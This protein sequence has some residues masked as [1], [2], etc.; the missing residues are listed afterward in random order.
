MALPGGGTA[1]MSGVNQM[2]KPPTLGNTALAAGVGGL[3]GAGTTR[4]QGMSALLGAG[5][6][7]ALSYLIRKYGKG[8]QKPGDTSGG[9]GGGGP[10]AI[11]QTTERDAAGTSAQAWNKDWRSQAS[12]SVTLPSSGPT[13]GPQSVPGLDNVGALPSPPP[14]A[15]SPTGPPQAGRLMMGTGNSDSGN[16]V[17][18]DGGKTWKDSRT[19]KAYTDPVLNQTDQVDPSSSLT[20]ATPATT[21]PAQGSADI[22]QPGRARARLGPD[23]MARQQQRLDRGL[24]SPGTG[25][26][27]SAGLEREEWRTLATPVAARRKRSR[28]P[29]D[30]A[31]QPRVEPVPGRRPGRYG[32]RRPGGGSADAA[33]LPRCRTRIPVLHTTIV[34]AA[35]PKKEKK[36]Q[37][38][39]SSSRRPCLPGAAPSHTAPGITITR[40]R[41]MA[42]CRF[43]AATEL[44]LKESDSAASTDKL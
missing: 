9:G 36:Q 1:S 42:E 32:G 28:Q 43:R 19:G 44:Q 3:M 17:S 30:A 24:I 23:F 33:S 35:K 2:V 37:A 13:G 34:I 5:L 27:A 4:N 21:P 40:P 7:G 25:G 16:V 14:G 10:A 12:P 29:P 39:R 41:R 20:S 15:L 38:A 22:I 26:R 18:W 8:A 6:S 11:P 31:R